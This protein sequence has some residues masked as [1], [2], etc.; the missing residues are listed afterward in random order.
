M[1]PVDILNSNNPIKV[2]RSCYHSKK[3]CQHVLF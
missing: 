2:D 3:L 1:T